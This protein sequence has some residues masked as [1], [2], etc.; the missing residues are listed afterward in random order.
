MP[1]V[2][3]EL[4][5]WD[6][7]RLTRLLVARPHLLTTRTLEELARAVVSTVHEAVQDLP[8]PHRQVLEAISLLPAGATVRDLLALDPGHDVEAGLSEIVDDLRARFLLRPGSLDLHLVGPVRHELPHPLGLGRGVDGC[9]EYT[10]YTEL[11]DLLAGLDQPRPR[12]RDAARAGLRELFGNLEDLAASLADLPPPALELLRRADRDGP[13]LAYPGVDPFQALLPDDPVLTICVLLGLLPVV[14]VN[15]VE[16]PQEVG[17]ALRWPAATRWQL[18]GPTPAALPTVAAHVDAACAE[19]VHRLLDDVDAVVAR[20][21]A[22]PV[23]LLASGSVGVKELRALASGVCEASSCATLLALLDRLGVIDKTR[24]DLRTTSQWP[25]WSALPESGRWSDLVRAWL[26]LTDLPASRPGSERR[27]KAALSFAYDTR[28]QPERLRLLRLLAGAPAL[29]YDAA[30]W[31]ACWEHRWPA[32]RLSVHD[33][34]GAVPDAELRADLLHEA[35]LL[36]LLA[37]GAATPLAKALPEQGDLAALLTRIAG[38]G[39]TGVRAQADLTLVCTGRPAREMKVALDRIAA[40]EQSGRAT[41]W[42]VSE[43][44]LTTAYDAGDTPEQ[45]DAVLERY[46]GTVPQAMSYLVKDAHRRHGRVRVGAATAYIVVDDDGVLQDALLRKGPAAK[47][48]KALGLRRVAPGVAVSRG[49]VAATVEA[50]R[51]LGVPA[52]A[53]TGGESGPSGRPRR[54]PAPAYSRPLPPLPRLDQPD[55]I[56]ARVAALLGS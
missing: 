9:H 29:S 21:E 41:V 40:V 31:L 15:R 55:E 6:S 51:A 45:V 36:G 33:R 47:T 38:A 53:E 19:A 52:V 28:L 23:P 7:A 39:E 13:V 44:S 3:D 5:S 48:A 42:R 24:K 20:I 11:C 10:P 1:T 22:K 14:G 30:G 17:L 46:A 26:G 56:A 18:D 49:S 50:L 37:D 25:A 4:R 34:P 35:G 43:Q 12:S 16:L 54:A 8:A 2:L 27:L 32:R